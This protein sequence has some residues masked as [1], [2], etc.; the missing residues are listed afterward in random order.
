MHSSRRQVRSIARLLV[1][2][3]LA[4]AQAL[5]QAG[6]NK[7]DI[8][9]TVYDAT[10]AVLPNARVTAINTATGFSRETATD[11]R[12]Q[13][14]FL[15]LDPGV[16]TLTASAPNFAVSRV[17]GVQLAVGAAITVNLTLE[18]QPTVTT[19]EVSAS[20]L[21]SSQPAPSTGIP[22]TAIVN[23]PINGR[24][25][26]DFA[27][28]TPTVQVEPERQMLSFAGQRGV[29]GN[30]MLDGG[31][32]NNPF[33]GGIR[34]GERSNFAFTVPQGAVEQFQ[35]VT[36]GYSAEYGRSTGGV[37]NVITKSG[38]NQV[39]GSAFWQFRDG[40]L[41]RPEPIFQLK[42]GETQHQFGGTLGGPI[43]R[44]RLFYFGAVERQDADA[45]RQ[46]L[47]NRLTGVTPAP[48][49]AEAFEFYKAQEQS[50]EATNN[51]TALT[52]RL[53]YQSARAGRIT[54]RYNFSDGTGENAVNTGSAISPITNRALSND[55][56]EQDR[57][58]TGTAQFTR[59]LT[60]SLLNDLRFTGTYEI[61]P[62][63][64]NSRTPQITTVVGVTGN[65]NFLP[66]TEDDVRYQ[67][68]DS[69]SW[70]K[71]SHNFKTGFDYNYVHA[72]QS[73]GFNQFGAFSFSVPG[74]AS[75]ATLTTLEVMSR[76]GPTADR[77]D[78]TSVVAYDL[79][80]GNLQA[81][82]T[83]HQ[84]AFFV[85][86]SW[87]ARP[88]LT[89]DFGLRWEGQFNPDPQ[90]TNTALVNLVKGVRSSF[91]AILDPTRIPNATNQWMPRFGFA[92]SPSQTGRRFV[93]RGHTG[94]FYASSPL[95]LFADA[96][97]NFRATPGN[98]S[99]RLTPFQ[100][101]T[102]YDQF[103]LV[104]IDL[105]NYTLDNLPVLT[106]EQVS[107]AFSL[108]R[109]VAPNPFAGATVGFVATDF[110]NPRSFQIGLG[111]E[112]ELTGNLVASLQF[113]YVNT[114][115]LQ[116]NRDHNLPFP[117][118]RASDASLRP[119]YGLNSGNQRPV[120]SLGA[121]TVRESS[122]RSMYR[123]LTLK[124]E[125]RGSHLTAGAFYTVSETFSDDDNERSAGG[126]QAL[127]QFNLRYDYGYSRIDL[128]HQFNSYAVYSLPWG[129]QVTGTVVARSGW[130]VNP[131][132]PGD[133]NQDG[134]TF[135]DRPYKAPGVPFGR[136]SFRNR[137]VVTANN[138]RVLKSFQMGERFRVQLSAEM[139][140]LFNL[141]NVVYGSNFGDDTY[142]LGIDPATGA[143]L[144]PDPGFRRLRCTPSTPCG[145]ITDNRYDTSNR[146]DGSPFQAQFGLRLLF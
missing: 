65:R 85:Q 80:I 106:P 64:A 87:R 25:F 43:L 115:H 68:T 79:Q 94:I 21:D 63:L 139:F 126:F 18:A 34:G 102:I 14:Q 7:G 61:R 55:G 11:A 77:F 140:N 24:R 130:P 146:Q 13:Y 71:G 5:A 74:S 103:K 44:D 136:M 143:V 67:I 33:F 128:R 144:P 2:G 75:Q 38:A 76:G 125:H 81:D 70:V 122:A 83:M 90:A 114:V 95:L 86:D 15:R 129:F 133:P 45:P 99:V 138:V 9:G 127:D 19:I 35:V 16:Y 135:S 22:E 120:P 49:H 66:T 29:N 20:L 108:A 50:F 92:Y 3:A 72:A 6:A 12:G 57:S 40:E 100:G 112:G 137:S 89:L 41:S 73:F 30:V 1:A 31:D 39:H 69:L 105:N 60:P 141:D 4:A 131:T 93:V 36:T 107:R 113:N 42:S 101:Q 47:F 96:S 84:S 117:A 26:Q 110:K 46:V 97:N 121:F 62:R 145:D 8:S 142:G 111:L 59:I 58:H 109:G 54:L 118:I 116:R 51:A 23:L 56:T 32:Y 48:E 37:L 10:Q 78:S 28:L 98:L 119:F 52:S 134:A 132:A 27:T 91:G 82:M 104:G 53:D 88:S 123:G 17:E 124:L